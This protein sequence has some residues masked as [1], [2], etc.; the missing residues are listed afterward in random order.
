MSRETQGLRWRPGWKEVQE[1]LKTREL[2]WAPIPRPGSFFRGTLSPI[3]ALRGG[4]RFENDNSDD[5]LVL[6]AENVDNVGKEGGI[7]CRVVGMVVIKQLA[8]LLTLPGY[9]QSWEM[10]ADDDGNGG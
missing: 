2:V 4:S 3:Q 1:E 6:L 7:L 8:C 5:K 9:N 10:I